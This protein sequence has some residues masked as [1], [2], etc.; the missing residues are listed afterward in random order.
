MADQDH[1]GHSDSLLLLLKDKIAL[2]KLIKQYP[3]LSAQAQ[4]QNQKKQRVLFKHAFA[5]LQDYVATPESQYPNMAMYHDSL[6]SRAVLMN[7]F[8]T[9]MIDSQ[10]Q[11]GPSCR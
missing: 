10:C 3:D 6:K 11:Q 2:Q 4:A 9:L 8:V 1:T 5:L 7:D